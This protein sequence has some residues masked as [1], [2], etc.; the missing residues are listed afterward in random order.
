MKKIV[1]TLLVCMLLVGSVFALASCFGGNKLSGTYEA[2]V[3]QNAVV[4]LTFDGDKVTYTVPGLD[5][6]GIEGLSGTYSIEDDK[7]TMTF[8]SPDIENDT[9]QSTVDS[10]VS[11]INAQLKNVDFAKDGD[12]IT[13]AG[14][15]F[16]KKK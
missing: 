7:I 16:T 1:S 12:T 4:S 5:E 10:I 8:T 14:Q 9:L 13:I 3:A 2:T 11:S 6:F 15:D